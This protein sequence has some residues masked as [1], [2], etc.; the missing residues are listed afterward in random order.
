MRLI[1]LIFFS[2]LITS[3]NFKD[4]PEYIFT[5]FVD[6]MSITIQENNQYKLIIS[7]CTFQ[8]KCEGEFTSFGDTLVI[9]NKRIK[10]NINRGEDDKWKK[11]GF[12]KKIEE[13]Y[14]KDFHY[15][16][17]TDSTLIANQVRWKNLVFER[18]NN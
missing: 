12:C 16:I 17:K 3:T 4:G 18:R 13:K 6:H 8:I 2:I 14:L 5:N 10:E 7:S 1:F 9:K 11:T 15:M